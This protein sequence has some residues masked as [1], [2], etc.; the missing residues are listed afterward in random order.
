[1][2]INHKTHSQKYATKDFIKHAIIPFL[3]HIINNI[4][5]TYILYEYFQTE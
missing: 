3:W 4:Y 5:N 2:L 1:M